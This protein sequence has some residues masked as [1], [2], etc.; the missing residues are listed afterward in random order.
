MAKKKN[1]KK[2]VKSNPIIENALPQNILPISVRNYG[3]NDLIF[4]R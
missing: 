4:L 2:S 1:S 3:V